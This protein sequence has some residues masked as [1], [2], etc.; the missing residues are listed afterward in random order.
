MDQSIQNILIV[1]TDRIGD[2]ILTLPMA[3]VIKHRIPGARVSMLI[4]RYTAEV[5]EDDPDVDSLIFDDRAPYFHMVGVLRKE[6]FDAVF[7]THPQFLLAL[8]TWLAGIPVRVGTGYRWYSFLFNRR[9]FEHRKDARRHELEYNLRLLAAI[10]CSYEGEDV[11]PRLAVG[12]EALARVA[13]LFAECGIGDHERFV[14]IHPGSGRSARDWDRKNFGALGR[15][16]ER[17]PGVRVVVTGGKTEHEIAGEVQTT[18]GGRSIALVDRMNVKEYAALVSRAALFVSNS[19][20][21]IHIAAAVGTPVIGLYPQVKPLSAARWGPYTQRKTI[22]SPVG[23]PEDCTKCLA[24][25]GGPCECMETISVD[26]V[27]DA[28]LRYLS[29][30]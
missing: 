26:S 14:V 29:G 20:G 2:V 17:I 25:K 12:R 8:Q 3:R 21:P 13:A 11:A 22:F 24:G 23:V 15:K 10:G 6:R 28:A 4:R 16:L 5:V 9:V 30:D 1:R 18:I 27:Y 7:H 19:T